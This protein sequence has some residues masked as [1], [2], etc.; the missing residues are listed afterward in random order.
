MYSSFDLTVS[1]TV[2][3][4][5]LLLVII[6]TSQ[7]HELVLYLVVFSLSEPLQHVDRMLPNKDGGAPLNAMFKRISRLVLYAIAFVLNNKQGCC[8]YQFFNIFWYKLATKINSKST[9]CKTFKIWHSQLS[10]TVLSTKGI[11]CSTNPQ[12]RFVVSTN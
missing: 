3:F 12:V 6:K 10:C 1:F 7:T 5:K 11:M 8:E 2:F 9:Y 4:N